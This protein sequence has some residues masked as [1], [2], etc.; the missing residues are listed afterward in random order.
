MRAAGPGEKQALKS[1]PD[2][3]TVPVSES[4]P[5]PKMSV[6]ACNRHFFLFLNPVFP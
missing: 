3:A 5:D 6:C 1:E 4:E 2:P